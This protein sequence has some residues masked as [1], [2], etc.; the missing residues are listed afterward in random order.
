MSKVIQFYSTTHMCL[1]TSLINTIVSDYWNQS[2]NSITG[3]GLL[4]TY[5]HGYCHGC[6]KLENWNLHLDLWKL[7]GSNNLTLEVAPV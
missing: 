7:I 3:S 4:T 1:F 2:R 6:L 5:A